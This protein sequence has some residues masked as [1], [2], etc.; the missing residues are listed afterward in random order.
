MEFESFEEAA[1]INDADLSNVA[2]LA[3]L[4]LEKEREIEEI[5][6]NLKI[7]KAQYRRISE[8]D[9]PE[10]M[11]SLGLATITLNNGASVSIKET[12]YASISKKNKPKAIEWLAEHD[13]ESLIQNEVTL[14][15]GRGEQERLRALRD[16]LDTTS[17]DEYAVSE[18]VNT[19]SVKSAIKELLAKGEDVPLELFG[20]HFVTQSIITLP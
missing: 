12:M 17:F 2:D 13:H 16:L 10:L 11:R 15:F 7:A 3:Q 20:V 6:R 1:L 9:L 4:Q 5:E 18:N 8:D 14:A 19:S